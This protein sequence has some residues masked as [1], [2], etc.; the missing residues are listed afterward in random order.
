MDW[1]NHKRMNTNSNEKKKERKLYMHPFVIESLH[2]QAGITITTNN[3][4]II[5]VFIEREPSPPIGHGRK[6]K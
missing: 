4:L 6:T 5:I 2:H 1:S 3:L